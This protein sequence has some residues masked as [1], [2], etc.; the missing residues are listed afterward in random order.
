MRLLPLRHVLIRREVI[1]LVAVV[2]HGGAELVEPEGPVRV[3]TVHVM[4]DI[5]MRRW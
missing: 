4:E 3:A 2:G 1:D 5:M